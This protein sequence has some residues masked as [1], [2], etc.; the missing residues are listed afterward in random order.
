M[1]LIS[2]CKSF[3]LVD[4]IDVAGAF[5]VK[6]EHSLLT[7]RE[8]RQFLTSDLDHMMQSFW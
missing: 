1:S 4:F 6:V 7:L 3:I 8:E 2:F 5:T